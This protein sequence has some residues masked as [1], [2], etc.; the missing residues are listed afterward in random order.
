MPFDIT[1]LPLL[2]AALLDQGL[3][4]DEIRRVMGDNVL[5]FLLT[6]L[7]DD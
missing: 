2:T 7:P 3:S 4:A 6:W 1:G 5:E